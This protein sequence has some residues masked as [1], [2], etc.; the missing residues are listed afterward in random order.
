MRSIHHH[1]EFTLISFFKIHNANKDGNQDLSK[2]AVPFI[3]ACVL[4]SDSCTRQWYQIKGRWNHVQLTEITASLK[5][6]TGSLL[7]NQKL[8]RNLKWNRCINRLISTI[9]NCMDF[10]KILSIPIPK[11]RLYFMLHTP[12]F[13]IVSKKTTDLFTIKN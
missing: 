7:W 3:D 9:S 1:I 4:Y 5:S 11:C 10:S 8:I 13:F 2:L 12:L 6:S